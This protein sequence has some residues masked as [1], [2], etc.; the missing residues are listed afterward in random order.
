METSSQDGEGYAYLLTKGFF[1]SLP[2]SYLHTTTQ[3][4]LI[5]GAPCYRTIIIFLKAKLYRYYSAGRS[6]V[7]KAEWNLIYGADTQAVPG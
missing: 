1:K 7:N 3:E 5:C 2:A 4:K 6:L